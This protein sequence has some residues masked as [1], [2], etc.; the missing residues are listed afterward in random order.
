MNTATFQQFQDLLQTWLRVQQQGVPE[1][2]QPCPG[3]DWDELRALLVEH[4]VEAALGSVLPLEQRTPELDHQMVEARHRTASLLMELERIIPGLTWSRC[5]PVVLKGAALASTLYPDSGQRWFV[6]LDILVPR[7]LLDEVCER[8]MRKGYQPFEGATDPE[9][10][11]R[12]HFHRIF[13]GPQGS[14]VEVHWDLVTPESNFAFDLEGLN[15]RALKTVVGCQDILVPAPVDQVL[16]GIYQNLA[17][18]FVDLRRVLDMGLLMGELAEEDWLYLVKQSR[19][20]GMGP[21]MHFWLHIIKKLLGLEA[22]PSVV[23][24]L[25]PGWVHQRVVRGLAWEKALL[26]RSAEK[27]EGA[28]NFLLFFLASGPV[29]KFRRVRR[30]LTTGQEAL[31]LEGHRAHQRFP[32]KTRLRLFLYFF[33]QFLLTGPRL[34]QAF[35][36]GS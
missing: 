5:R 32:I 34:L 31:F 14:C 33:K 29:R 16:H 7:S 23:R 19:R 36:R 4:K 28:S 2:V 15:R 17:D 12:F 9:F 13:L 8:L 6:D 10:Y 25:A 27:V 24:A 21:A 35:F 11:E 3:V 26:A 22:P 1:T 18:G 30:T 20:A